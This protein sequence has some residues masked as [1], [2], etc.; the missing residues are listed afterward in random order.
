M[1]SQG[2]TAPRN[3]TPT[4]CALCPSPSGL[5]HPHINT[6][7]TSSPQLCACSPSRGTTSPK[8]GRK[9]VRV[10]SLD[11]PIPR[12]C[13]ALQPQAPT[14]SNGPRRQQDAHAKQEAASALLSS[15][16]RQH[17]RA[18]LLNVMASN[19][20]LQFD[21]EVAWLPSSVLNDMSLDSEIKHLLAIISLNRHGHL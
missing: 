3:Q 16:M 15:V 13:R 2:Q 5:P 21:S 8:A 7:A 19:C 12:L 10:Y 11:I 9:A 4:G 17:P 14:A 6:S 1:V 20:S 18:S